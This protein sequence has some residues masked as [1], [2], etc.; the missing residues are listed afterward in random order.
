MTIRSVT[1][2][3]KSVRSTSSTELAIKLMNYVGCRRVRMNLS[4]KLERNHLLCRYIYCWERLTE[5]LNERST[6]PL[7]SLQMKIVQ[8][9]EHG[10]IYVVILK[11]SN[12]TGCGICCDIS[13]LNF[14]DTAVALP[15]FAES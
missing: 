14:N 2:R 11:C 7:E 8:K 3:L 15:Y 12:R 1:T 6:N 9:Y 13:S 10:R 5:V 4:P